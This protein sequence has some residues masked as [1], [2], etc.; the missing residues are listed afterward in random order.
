MDSQIRNIGLNPNDGILHVSCYNAE[1]FVDEG[2]IVD[3]NEFRVT[4]CYKEKGLHFILSNNEVLVLDKNE[5]V[6]AKLL[7]SSTVN[8]L[9]ILERQSKLVVTTDK[10]LFLFDIFN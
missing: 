1:Y 6:L 10:R 4:K 8:S 5:N 9:E 7:F 3:K 2:K